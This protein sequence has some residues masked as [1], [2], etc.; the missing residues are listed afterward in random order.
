MEGCT[1]A[2][3]GPL[4]RSV[5]WQRSAGGNG[6]GDLRGVPSPGSRKVT[7]RESHRRVIRR[8]RVEVNLLTNWPDRDIIPRRKN[9]HQKKL[10]SYRRLVM[11][12]KTVAKIG[13]EW[14][15]SVM[16]EDSFRF[17]LWQELTD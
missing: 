8:E 1:G 17:G 11:M 12:S 13:C 14:P 9:S 15:Q 4:L 7:A 6:A 5:G 2:G 3:I 16:N 10:L